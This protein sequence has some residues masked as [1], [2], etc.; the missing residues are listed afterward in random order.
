MVNFLW[1]IYINNCLVFF[2]FL[3]IVIMLFFIIIGMIRIFIELDFFMIF[4]IMFFIG[5]K[6][7]INVMDLIMLI[8]VI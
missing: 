5:D 4:I 2:I 7:L 3:L 8:F 1:I 6:V